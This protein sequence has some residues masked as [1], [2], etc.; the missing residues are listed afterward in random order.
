[1]RSTSTATFCSPQSARTLYEAAA[2]LGEAGRTAERAVAARVDQARHH[3]WIR[4]VHWSRLSRAR[5]R[6][7][8]PRADARQTVVPGMDPC[9]RRYPRHSATGRADHRTAWEIEAHRIEVGRLAVEAAELERQGR[10][11]D[12]ARLGPRRADPSLAAAA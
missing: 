11:V 12:P 2:Q 5:K 6:K 1:M 4:E 7:L 10:L 3:W 9:A 8:G